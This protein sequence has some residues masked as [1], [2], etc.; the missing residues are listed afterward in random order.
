LQDLDFTE[1]DEGTSI[2]AQKICDFINVNV[3]QLRQADFV[4]QVSGILDKTAI[5]PHCLKPQLTESIVLNDVTDTIAKMRALN[6]L[7][8]RIDRLPPNGQTLDES[9]H[10]QTRTLNISLFNHL[11]T[12]TCESNRAG[13][14]TSVNRPKDTQK[15]SYLIN[16]L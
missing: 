4:A 3:R 2:V 15:I 14:C 5:N 16:L 11:Q 9:W 8:G 13:R 7:G 6:R 1:D 10:P 12:D